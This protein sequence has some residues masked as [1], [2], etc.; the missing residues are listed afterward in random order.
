MVS[1][2]PSDGIVTDVIS[3]WISASSGVGVGGL[4]GG[5]GSSAQAM[6]SKGKIADKINSFFMAGG[7]NVSH[8]CL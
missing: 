4:T 2:P 6:K 3:I 1:E 5:G 8:N 7:I